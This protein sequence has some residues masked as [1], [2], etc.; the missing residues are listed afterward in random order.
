LPD[1]P[2]VIDGIIF[3]SKPKLDL[4]LFTVYCPQFSFSS[5]NTS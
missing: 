1:V 3:R 5:D 2:V 4:L